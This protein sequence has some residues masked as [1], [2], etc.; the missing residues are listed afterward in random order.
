MAATDKTYR[1]FIFHFI[2]NFSTFLEERIIDDAI[3]YRKMTPKMTL[4]I[5]YFGKYW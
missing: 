2:D 3:D 5:V 4:L 1:F